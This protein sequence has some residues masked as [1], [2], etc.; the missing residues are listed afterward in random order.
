MQEVLG[1]AQVTDDPPHVKEVKQHL[2]T[3]K[4]GTTS[5]NKYSKQMVETNQRSSQ[6]L[7][8]LANSLTN[9]SQEYSNSPL[10]E[11]LNLTSDAE[12]SLSA[13]HQN[14]ATDTNEGLTAYMKRLMEDDLKK[15]TDVKTKHEEAR[16]AY[17]I[18]QQKR[19]ELN[20][21][22]GDP[23]YQPKI[24]ECD[25][26][27]LTAQTNYEN[28]GDELVHRLNEFDQ[29]S[30]EDVIAN[31][32]RLA[33]AQL[34]FFRNGQALLSKLVP[35]L[36]TLSSNNQSFIQQM[37][38]ESHVQGINLHKP[39]PGP[40]SPNDLPSYE[41]FTPNEVNYQPPPGYSDPQV[42][43]VAYNAGPP[44]YSQYSNAF[45]DAKPLPNPGEQPPSMYP[46]L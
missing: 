8:K 7:D 23:K 37:M 42:V 9:Y 32:I 20:S 12:K 1:T 17:D 24:D 38:E 18:Q 15:I 4:Q 40:S 35:Q 13:L 44:D 30:S 26:N 29:S 46:Q 10:G 41:D 11:A 36:E 2:R 5:I 22:L 16:V 33:Q 14:L 6:T 28:I 3:V 19:K 31:L 21:K 45:A 27:L 25:Q 39:E 43:P 34:E